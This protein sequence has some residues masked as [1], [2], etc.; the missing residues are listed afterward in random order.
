MSGPKVIN[1]EAVRRRQKRESLA[2]L[3]KLQSALAQCE[4]WQ[5][6]PQATAV[7]DRL[8]EMRDAEQWESLSLEAARQSSFYEDEA[9]RLRQQHVA[10][11]AADLRRVHRLRQSV[12]QMTAHLEKLPPSLE[13]EHLIAQLNAPDASA[14]QMALND[15]LQF[16]EQDHRD[17]ITSRMRELAAGLIAPEAV[18]SALPDLPADPQE[19]RL[20]K[21]WNLLGELSVFMDA[22]DLESLTA[23]A[24]SIAA[25]HTDQ[26]TLLLDSLALELSTYLQNRRASLALRSELELLLAELDE[27]HSPAAADWKK[28]IAAALFESSPLDPIRALA[29]EARSWV[30]QTFAEETRQEQRAAVLR[31]LA[32]TGYEVREG[33]AAAWVEQGRM[34]LQK[35]GESAYGVELSAPALGNAVQTRV[36]AFS[37][38]GRDPL[39]DREVEDTWCGEFEKARDALNE[40][41]FN[42]SLVQ[43]HP[44]GTI[45]LKAVSPSSFDQN[46]HH[47]GEPSTVTKGKLIG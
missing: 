7:V 8:H 41:G 13:R 31:A 46:A 42:A 25:A 37:P 22:V 6:L 1:I 20:E 16:I 35:P 14:Q 11:Q 24:R 34:V 32:A 30:E 2:H 33:M 44:A 17:E 40:A 12:A 36:V 4:R 21:C 38:S 9:Q 27:I 28:R 23:K 45:P 39:R 26:Q 18:I 19:Q 47:R 10:E 3:Q 15:T 5:E 43:A 29:Q